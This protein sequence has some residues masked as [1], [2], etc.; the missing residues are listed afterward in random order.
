LNTDWQVNQDVFGLVTR[1]P[2]PYDSEGVITMITSD[3]SRAIEEIA[4]VLTDEQ[5]FAP[6]AAQLGW[7]SAVPACFQCLFE[8]RLGPVNIDT[9]ARPAR[10]VSARTY[11][12]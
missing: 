8:I 4:H 1:I 10:L 6:M 7:S 3:Y 2:N 5:R 11:E 9:E 12:Q